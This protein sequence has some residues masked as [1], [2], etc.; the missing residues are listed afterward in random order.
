MADAELDYYEVLGVER[1]ATQEEIKKS[2]RR[3]AMKYH[4]DR[5]Q[6]DK[7]AEEKFKQ[8]GEAYEVLSDPQ[9]RAAYDRYGHSAF[10]AGGNGGAGG[11]GGFGGFS[12]G[13]NFNDIGDIFSEIFGQQA[14][15]R[16]GSKNM[17]RGKDLQYDIEITLEQ[18]AEGYET[19]IK[20]PSWSKCEEC[21]GTGARK[22]TQPKTCPTCNGTG[23]VRMGNGFFQV[24]QTCPTCHGKGKVIEKPCTHCHGTGF[25]EERK[26]LQIKIPAGIDD[27]QRIRM[28]GR[29]APGEN[30]G[31]N[32]DLYVQVNI[33]E[34]ELFVR[35]DDDLHLELPISFAT[36]ALGGELEVP[37][38]KG[39]VTLKIPEATQTGKIFRLKE[40]G[41][42]GLRTGRMG[43][44]YVHTIVETPVNLTKEQ[45]ELLKKFE[46][47]LHSNG[48]K[49]HAPDS[50][51]FF[52]KLGD[53]FN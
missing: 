31:A 43:D 40:K 4:P 18:A 6:G 14:R 7:G 2:Y 3:L 44:M 33:K 27:G 36:A 52:E 8:V 24:E 50:K 11:F 17:R 35:E 38:L 46:A 28:S 29:G 22:G 42:K 47:S 19:E 49:H 13:G 37:T 21:N 9:K 32:G 23:S 53:L 20:V 10:Q 15:S 5:N 39:K 30:G 41:I 51:S 26:T 34:H 48:M 45:K 12:G 25:Q 16:G 1:T